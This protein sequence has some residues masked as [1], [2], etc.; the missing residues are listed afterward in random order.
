VVSKK[1]LFFLQEIEEFKEIFKTFVKDQQSKLTKFPVFKK[2]VDFYQSQ[3]N[4]NFVNIFAELEIDI[5]R[6]KEF[7][8][9]NLK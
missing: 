4:F 3:L 5:K 9:W 7:K 2:G 8:N 6:A 1:A